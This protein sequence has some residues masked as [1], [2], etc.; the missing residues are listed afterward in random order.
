VCIVV[1]FLCVL[2]IYIFILCF[3]CLGLAL[4]N[5][6]LFYATKN[7]PT[8]TYLTISQMSISQTHISENHG[9]YDPSRTQ[10]I[11]NGIASTGLRHCASDSFSRFL[12]LYKF[13]CIYVYGGPQLHGYTQLWAYTLPFLS[14][15][16]LPL[17]VRGFVIAS[18]IGELH[19]VPKRLVIKRLNQKWTGNGTKPNFQNF[20]TER[21][22][23]C[24]TDWC[25]HGALWGP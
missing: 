6:A 9:L 25:A 15:G 20:Q 19:S 12:A 5:L 17:G 22:C 23:T 24:Q 2:W 14:T 16:F 4:W 8:G 3:L 18:T 13:V 10:P 21:A 11:L 1:C 7:L